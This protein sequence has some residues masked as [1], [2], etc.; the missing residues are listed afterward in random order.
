VAS[1]HLPGPPSTAPRHGSPPMPGRATQTGV[2]KDTGRSR[3]KDGGGGRIR[4]KNRGRSRGKDGGGGRIRGKNRGRSRGKNRD[5]SK[6]KGG[7]R[8]QDQDRDKA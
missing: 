1:R 3:G 4:G 8:D 5:S 6:D 2:D 7:D